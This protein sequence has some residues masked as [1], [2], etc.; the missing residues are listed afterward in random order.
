M[1]ALNQICCPDLSLAEFFALATR[2]G[3]RG[4]ELRN[5]MGRPIFGGHSGRDVGRMASDAGLEI[6]ALAQVGSFDLADD[7]KLEEARA[8]LEMAGQC[9][10]QSVALIA[11]NN[12]QLPP[13][14]VQS[15][16]KVLERYQPLF[17]G[18]G[19]VG[20]VEPLG[21]ASCAL[22]HKPVLSEAISM[23][24]GEAEFGIIHDTF[25]HYLA[26]DSLVGPGIALVHISGVDVLE[27][28][29]LQLVD[30]DRGLVDAGDRLKNIEQIRDLQRLGYS[31]A[32]SFEPFA[33][34]ICR[35]PSHEEELRR[36]MNFILSA[37][38]GNEPANG[39]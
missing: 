17:A 36:S 1:F 15:V 3:C 28:P 29:R 38:G 34:E 20:A 35:S 30:G 14:T 7:H 25:H 27:R 24:G 39:G 13:H 4:V 16:A 2:L 10:A 9:G 26:E 18:T 23:V 31:G 19:I 8:L 21:F 12:S 33:V 6:F 32:L 22:R 11:D 37:V 5:D